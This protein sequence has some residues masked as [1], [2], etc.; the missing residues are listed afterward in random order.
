MPFKKGQRAW[1]KGKETPESVKIKQSLSHKGK[2]ISEETK[3]KMSGKVPWN[4]GSGAYM[5]GDKNSNW[6]GGKSM[7]NGY[8]CIYSPKHPNKSVRNYVFEH[9]LVMEK[10][11]GRYLKKEEVVHHIDKNHANNKIENLMLFK[12]GGEHTSFH[13][14]EKSLKVKE[15]EDE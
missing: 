4:K 1:N 13:A 9:R 7:F 11:I 6:R 10:H 14:L 5:L 3:I 12:N 8:V 15:S 2:I